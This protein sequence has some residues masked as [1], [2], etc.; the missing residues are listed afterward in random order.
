ML[1]FAYSVGV[2]VLVGLIDCFDCA[3]T[4][5]LSTQLKQ[6][7][8]QNRRTKASVLTISNHMKKVK[9]ISALPPTWKMT[10]HMAAVND[11]FGGD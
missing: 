10:V 9:S 1:S 11:V 2:F 7:H 5:N 3:V 6:T 8:L 4:N